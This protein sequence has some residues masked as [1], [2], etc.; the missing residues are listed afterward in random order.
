MY[1][2]R[3]LRAVLHCSTPV[4]HRAEPARRTSTSSTAAIAALVSRHTRTWSSASL[5]SLPHHSNVYAGLP[6]FASATTRGIATMSKVEEAKSGAKVGNSWTSSVTKSGEYKRKVSAFRNWVKAD[7]STDFTPE[8]G[9]YTLYVSLACPWAH[10]T[11]I[12]RKLKGLEDAIDVVVVHWYLAEGGWRFATAEDEEGDG[13]ADPHN[14]AARMRELYTMASSEYEGNITVPVLWD[15]K[16]KAIVNNESSEIIRMLNSE[17]QEFASEKGKALD[18]YPEAQREAIDAVNEWVYPHINN[19]VYRCG[20]AKSQEAYATAFAG[21]FEHLD[22]AEAV[23]AKSRYIA[24]D[25]L[26]EADVRL[27]TTLVRFDPVYFGHFKCNKK[28]IVDYPNLSNY[29]RDIYQTCGIA[30]TVDMKH[31]KYHYYYSHVHIN[32]TQVVP[33]GPEQN[34]DA[35]H[36]RARL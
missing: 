18:L 36:D 5:S 4:A 20:F 21:L 24:G 31:I 32:P 7:G 29:V 2:R 17:F 6:A 33:L 28:R 22:R 15:K 1:P 13:M 30:E 19:G 3:I 27:F 9:C 26:T 34:L 14:G 8:S 25:A 23:L 16:T 10:R 35:P 12:T 11:L